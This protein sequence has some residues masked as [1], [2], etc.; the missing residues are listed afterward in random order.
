VSGPA[1]D[2]AGRWRLCVIVDAQRLRGRRP[3][4]V[5]AAA[6][7]GGATAIQFRDKVSSGGALLE[8]AAAV[9][10]VCRRAGVI[11]IVNDRVDVA[12]AA[13]ADGAHV[14]QD[15][16]PARAARGILGPRRILGVS[17]ATAEQAIRAAADGADYIGAGPVFDARSTKADA[18]PPIGLAGLA[19]V[20]SAT[21][22]PVLA[23]G[24]IHAGN[25]RQALA[26]GA[27]G[28]AVI[29]A[30]LSADDVEAATRALLPARPDE[31]GLD[32]E[33]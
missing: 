27:A 19:A 31:D 24:G 33:C 13:E 12:L 4:A 2:A 22:L 8:A 21:P 1:P 11:S 15:D 26:A 9:A 10:R 29:S 7:A 23:I 6:I 14:G 30:V 28:V 20:C 32:G 16:L 3:E 17:A 5:A 18:G 25:A